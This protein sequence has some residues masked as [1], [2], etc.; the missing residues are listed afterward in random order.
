M[1]LFYEEIRLKYF[2]LVRLQGPNVLFYFGW[3]SART[4]RRWARINVWKRHEKSKRPR[5]SVLL[6][7]NVSVQKPGSCVGF[8]VNGTTYVAVAHEDTTKSPAANVSIFRLHPDLNFTLVSPLGWLFVRSL[9]T[10]HQQ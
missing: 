1:Q 10:M 9:A 5:L 4:M 7:Q 6:L 8:T 3:K 2:I